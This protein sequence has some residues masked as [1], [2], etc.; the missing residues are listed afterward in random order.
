M[1][2]PRN[3]AIVM[4]ALLIIIGIALVIFQ[5]IVEFKRRTPRYARGMTIA[6][7]KVEIRTTHPGLIMICVGAGLILF[8]AALP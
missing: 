8:S 1:I 3:A 4:G 2:T 6:P 7:H 5:M